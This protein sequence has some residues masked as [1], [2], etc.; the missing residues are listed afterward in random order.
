MPQLVTLM[1]VDRNFER[2]LCTVTWST[3][4]PRHLTLHDADCCWLRNRRP[5]PSWEYSWNDTPYAFLSGIPTMLLSS[6]TILREN[7]LLIVEPS[8]LRDS[9]WSE[10]RLHCQCINQGTEATTRQIERPLLNMLDSNT[11]DS[12][13]LPLIHTDYMQMR[14]ALFSAGTL[15]VS[16]LH[17]GF[18]CITR[19]MKK[20]IHQLYTYRCAPVSNSLEYFHLHLNRF[21]PS[22]HSVYWIKFCVNTID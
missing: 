4:M 2:S 11:N 20:G 18:S 5:S 3:G 1:Y 14:S 9:T 13:C 6:V 16:K 19:T 7:L 10:L 17:Q 22:T 8:S 15:N 12:L 21:I